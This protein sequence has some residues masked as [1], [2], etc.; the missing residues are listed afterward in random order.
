MEKKKTEIGPKASMTQIFLD[1]RE[2]F[3]LRD[4]FKSLINHVTLQTF[5]IKP[6]DRV[7][8]FGYFTRAS[9]T[10]ITK[11]MILLDRITLGDFTH[12]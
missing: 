11:I 9:K 12:C 2:S 1:T 3:I 7:N 5:L 8:I 6:L 10:N 4:V